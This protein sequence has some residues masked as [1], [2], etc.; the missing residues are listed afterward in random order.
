M[1]RRTL[2]VLIATALFRSIIFF[3]R[4]RG[5]EKNSRGTDQSVISL[6]VK[7]VL[8][9]LFHVEI[10]EIDL[11]KREERETFFLLS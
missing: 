8:S 3:D 9:S 10:F 2:S 5:I 7:I 11:N 6:S 1:I 4:G